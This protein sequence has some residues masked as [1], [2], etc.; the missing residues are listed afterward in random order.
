MISGGP[1]GENIAAGVGGGYN[2]EKA[3]NSWANE[4]GMSTMSSCG[5]IAN[6]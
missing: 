2:I 4:D 3:F 5:Y 6:R 1:N